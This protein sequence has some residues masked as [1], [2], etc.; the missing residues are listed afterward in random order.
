MAPF[1]LLNQRSSVDW[2]A[3]A[4]RAPGTVVAKTSSIYVTQLK[5]ITLCRRCTWDTFVQPSW[6]RFGKAVKYGKA[7]DKGL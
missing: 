1:A 6:E 4:S 3:R 7:F 5:D 2:A